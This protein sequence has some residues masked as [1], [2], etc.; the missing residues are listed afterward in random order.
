MIKSLPHFILRNIWVNSNK[1]ITLIE[2]LVA[3]GLSGLMITFV[4][5]SN[6]FVNKLMID[7]QRKAELEDVALLCINTLSKDIQNT[8]SLIYFSKDRI[9]LITDQDKRISYSVIGNIL[10]RNDDDLNHGKITLDDI[11][12]TCFGKSGAEGNAQTILQDQNQLD[13]NLNLKLDP[14][15]L[16]EVTGIRI[17]LWLKGYGKSLNVE[18]YVRLKKSYSVY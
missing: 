15:E 14:D 8:D 12:L 4:L 10:R 17:R 11:E 13:K 6:F 18:N 2:V 16:N 5:Y 9:E 1:G 7:W 3:C